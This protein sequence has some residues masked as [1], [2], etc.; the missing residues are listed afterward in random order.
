MP[1]CGP[2]E[3]VR[4]E[5]EDLLKLKNGTLA[6]DEGRE[7]G[8]ADLVLVV[9]LVAMREAGSASSWGAQRAAKHARERKKDREVTHHVVEE[10]LDETLRGAGG[11]AAFALVATDRVERVDSAGPVTV[12]SSD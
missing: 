4:H 9:D 5:A 11:P 6:L 1:F 7:R 8:V 2:G 12:D 10:G 3:R